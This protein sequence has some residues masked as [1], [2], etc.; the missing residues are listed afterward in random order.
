LLLSEEQENI[1]H[2]EPIEINKE[3]SP[4]VMPNGIVDQEDADEKNK[5]ISRYAY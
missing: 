1:E 2:Y 4:V 5:S 3:D